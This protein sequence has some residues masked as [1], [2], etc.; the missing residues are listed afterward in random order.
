[1]KS[2]GSV[3]TVSMFPQQPNGPHLNKSFPSTFAD[4][5]H[6]NC[7]IDLLSLLTLLLLSCRILDS[8]A[9]LPN[10]PTHSFVGVFV[11]FTCGDGDTP[12]WKETFLWRPWWPNAPALWHWWRWQSSRSASRSV[13]SQ[14]LGHLATSAIPL[15]GRVTIDLYQWGDN[16]AGPSHDESY[17]QVQLFNSTSRVR[18]HT[19]KY[20]RILFYHSGFFYP[21]DPLPSHMQRRPDGDC[22]YRVATCTEKSIRSAREWDSILLCLISSNIFQ[23]RCSLSFLPVEFWMRVGRQTNTSLMLSRSISLAKYNHL[24]QGERGFSFISPVT[25]NLFHSRNMIFSLEAFFKNKSLNH[26]KKELCGKFGTSL[27][28]H[29]VA[30]LLNTIQMNLLHTLT[31]GNTADT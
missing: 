12:G 5:C 21:S 16:T 26:Q 29:I 25:F 8:N 4:I 3:M 15:E 17:I 2:S 22:L 24:F 23:G 30:M 14:L 6:W 27:L 20:K 11:V 28:L 1:M 18:A 7:T 31:N 9:A 10:L 13:C 19:K